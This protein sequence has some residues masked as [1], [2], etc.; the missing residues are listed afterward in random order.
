MELDLSR[1]DMNGRKEKRRGLTKLK[2]HC[3]SCKYNF[4]VVVPIGRGEPDNDA[5]CPICGSNDT[6]HGWLPKK[7]E[8]K[9]M[10]RQITLENKSIKDHE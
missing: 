8:K 5:I 4:K 2:Y 6:Y 10:P 3:N 7:E 1:W 9:E